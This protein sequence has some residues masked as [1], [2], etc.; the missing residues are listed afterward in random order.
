MARRRHGTLGQR[1]VGGC[2]SG[3]RRGRV[4][5]DRDLVLLQLL[6]SERLQN[7]ARLHTAWSGT[8]GQARVTHGARAA[9][10]EV[11]ACGMAREAT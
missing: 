9:G 4:R 10:K 6:R 3:G 5:L 8:H 2:L 11:T 7:G 1:L